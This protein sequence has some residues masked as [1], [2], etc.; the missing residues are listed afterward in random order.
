MNLYVEQDLHTSHPLFINTLMLIR[1]FCVR[2]P[3]NH[4]SIWCLFLCQLFFRAFPFMK[5][6]VPVTR[7]LS[8][9]RLTVCELIQESFTRK[10]LGVISNERKG[11]TSSLQLGVEFYTVEVCCATFVH[12]EKVMMIEI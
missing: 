1:C 5:K 4:T 6:N 12:S 9:V 2:I 11:Q 8:F 3:D 10:K 7:V